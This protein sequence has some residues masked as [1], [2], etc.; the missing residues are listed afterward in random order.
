MSGLTED[1]IVKAETLYD[2]RFPPDLK[3][4]LMFAL[5]VSSKWINW[6]KLGSNDIKAAFDWVYEGIYFDIENNVFWLEDWGEKP[7]DLQ[8]AFSI[9]KQKIDEAP[10]LIPIYSHRYMPTEPNERNNPVFSVYQTDIVYY[11]NNIW[12]YFEKEFP[13]HFQTLSN[14]IEKPIKQIKFWSLFAEEL[15]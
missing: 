9:A 10:K 12:D 7:A 13:H 3:E 6:R 14:K 2:F 5:P 11:G 1:E 8:E 15:I 4:F